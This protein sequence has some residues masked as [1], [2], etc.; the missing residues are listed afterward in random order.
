[1]KD[2]SKW[3]PSGLPQFLKQDTDACTSYSTIDSIETQ[4]LALTGSQPQYSRRWLAYISKTSPTQGNSLQNVFPAVAKLGLVLE[5]SWPQRSDM[6]SEEFY[7]PPTPEEL[8]VL[9]YEGQAWLEKWQVSYDFFKQ[10]SDLDKAPLIVRLNLTSTFHFVE[11][12]NSQTYYDSE[13]HNG[14][15]GIIPASMYP[16]VVE[17]SQLIINLKNMGQFK[18]QNYKGELR[19]VLQADS[20][21]TWEALCKVYAV[22][23]KVINEIIN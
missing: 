6:T 18:T 14:Y 11:V 4:E 17:Y 7:T 12:L 19:I 21:Q 8:K 22:D 5:S 16:I 15:I 2:W 13:Y 9:A 3:L 1:M 10:L 20:E 23:P